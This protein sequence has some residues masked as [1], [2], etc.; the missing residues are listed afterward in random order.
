MGFNNNEFPGLPD[1]FAPPVP[2]SGTYDDYG[3]DLTPEQ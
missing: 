2:S 1:R 3:Y